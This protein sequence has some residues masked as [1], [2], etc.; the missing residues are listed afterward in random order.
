MSV[1]AR[2]QNASVSLPGAATSI[3]FVAT[4]TCCKTQSQSVSVFLPPQSLPE[5][6]LNKVFGVKESTLE[7]WQRD[8]VAFCF[9]ERT[10]TQSDSTT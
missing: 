5:A 10:H 6:V 8:T 9:M 1:P 2:K 7:D 3:I 4:N